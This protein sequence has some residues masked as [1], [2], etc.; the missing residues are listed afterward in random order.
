MP[1]ILAGPFAQTALEGAGGELTIDFGYY[2]M[3][4]E[5]V[6]RADAFP[7]QTSREPLLVADWD[8]Y[9]AAIETA[10]RDPEL[11]LGREVWARGELGP[12]V[13]PSRP[14][15]TPRPTPRASPRRPSSPRAPSST[16]RAGRWTTCGRSPW[17]PVCSAWSA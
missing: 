13:E 10:N 4:V 5:V 15:D 8:R 7:G 1:V 14:P 16:R 9:V 17:P 3:P 6:G 11:V 2:T 12:A